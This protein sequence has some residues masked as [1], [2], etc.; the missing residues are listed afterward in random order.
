MVWTEFD[1]ILP[2]AI[3][4][5]SCSASRSEPPLTPG[6]ATGYALEKG[7]VGLR[8]VLNTEARENAFTTAEDLTPVVQ[9]LAGHYDILTELPRLWRTVVNVRVPLEAENF[10]TNLVTISF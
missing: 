2:S 5:G 10:W 4:V 1:W 7:W 9:S 8:T 6:N 3:D